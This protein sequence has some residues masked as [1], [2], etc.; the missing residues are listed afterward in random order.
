[1]DRERKKEDWE[2]LKLKP[3]AE[4][5]RKPAVSSGKSSTIKDGNNCVRSRYRGKEFQVEVSKFP[6][7]GHV[8]AKKGP[9]LGNKGGPR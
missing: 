6:K 9:I 8:K 7:K 3:S 4:E 2:T 5:L 1:V